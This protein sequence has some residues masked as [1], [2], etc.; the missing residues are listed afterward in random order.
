MQFRFGWS[1][2]VDKVVETTNRRQNA[3]NV[4]F[5]KYINHHHFLSVLSLHF[6]GAATG[7]VFLSMKLDIAKN[8]LTV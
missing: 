1:L 7:I 2:S 5:Y 4:L 3:I 8:Y 6:Y